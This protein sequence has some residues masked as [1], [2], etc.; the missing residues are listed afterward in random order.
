L[1]EKKR[2]EKLGQPLTA[3]FLRRFGVW[4]LCLVVVVF[5]G[6]GRGVPTDRRVWSKQEKRK[7]K[8]RKRWN[9]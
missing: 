4:E 1:E 6:G 7:R 3:V 2:K 9:K 5:G 8:E